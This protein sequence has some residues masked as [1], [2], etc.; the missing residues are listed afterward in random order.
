MEEMN[1][2]NAVI[3]EGEVIDQYVKGFTI[4][5]VNRYGTTYLSCSIPNRKLMHSL[6]EDLL[7][8]TIRCTGTYIKGGLIVEHAE[9]KPEEVDNE[10]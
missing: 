3:I 4:K 10:R 1:W 5:N 6:G 9:F 8:K 2:L 7:G